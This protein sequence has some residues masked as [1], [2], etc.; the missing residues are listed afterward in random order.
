MFTARSIA[1]WLEVACLAALPSATAAQSFN[2]DLNVSG[3][4]GAGEPTAGFVTPG[5]EGTWNAITGTSTLF[6]GL[7][8][9]TNTLTTARFVR[10]AGT[11]IGATGSG[12]SADFQRLFYDFVPITAINEFVFQGLQPGRYTVYSY[13]RNVT[14]PTSRVSV[15]V[16][17]GL[18]GI[19]EMLPGSPTTFALGVNTAVHAID[20]LANG[21][22]TIQVKNTSGI[23]GVNGFQI[24]R[25][26][27]TRLYVDRSGPVEGDGLS[28]GT[29]F[30]EL[31]TAISSANNLTSVTEIW[32]ADGT[33]TPAPT[34]G[35]RS[36]SFQ[37][38]RG[39]AIYGGFAGGE[40]SLSQRNPDLNK[41]ILSG[42]LRAD[43]L[44]S[45]SRADNSYRVLDLPTAASNA[46]I[47][48]LTISGGQ[49]DGPAAA[50]Q[51]GAGIGVEGSSGVRIDRCTIS[52]NSASGESAAAGILLSSTTGTIVSR[53]VFTANVS[54]NDQFGVSALLSTQGSDSVVSCRFERNRG[55]LCVAAI[56]S[57]LLQLHNSLIA[58]NAG[59][60]AP[61]LGNGE[62]IA[63]YY[64]F[65]SGNI[66]HCTIAGNLGGGV[67]PAAS[68]LRIAN[69]VIRG[70]LLQGGSP[71]QDVAPDPFEFTVPTIV[72]SSIGNVTGAT[73]SNANPML[74]SILGNDLAPGSGD[75]DFALLPAS[76]AADQA[77]V[78]EIPPDLADV[79]SDGNTAEPLPLDLEGSPRR[80]DLTGAPDLSGQTSSPDQGAFECKTDVSRWKDPAGATGAWSTAS[81]WIPDGEPGADRAAFFPFVG[82]SFATTTVSGSR[83]TDQLIVSNWHYFFDATGS[84]KTIAVSPQRGPGAV[85]A[86]GIESLQQVF[87]APWF[88]QGLLNAAGYDVR[89]GDRAVGAYAYANF[90]RTSG[91]ALN[92]RD[93]LVDHG[94]AEIS[95]GTFNIS[96]NLTIGSDAYLIGGGTVNGTVI[97]HGLI[98]PSNTVPP[99]LT[100]NGS[101]IQRQSPFATDPAPLTRF[102]V[103]TSGGGDR[104]V[105]N[106]L[107]DFSGTVQMS[108]PGGAPV[109]PVGTQ[110][111]ILQYTARRGFFSLASL[112]ATADRLVRLVYAD[113]AERGGGLTAQVETRTNV[114]NLQPPLGFAV[115]GSPAAAAT[116]RIHFTVDDYPDLA[117]V[118]PDASNPTT[119]N[120]K[121]H[122]LIN[123]GLTANQWNGW[124]VATIIKS[125]DDP[126]P[127]AHNGFNPSGVC[128]AD[129]TGDGKQDVAVCNR[130]SGTV[131]RF[132]NTSTSIANSLAD[133]VN[134]LPASAGCTLPSSIAAGDL[135]GDGDQDLVVSCTGNNQLWPLFNTGGGTFTVPSDAQKIPVGI[136]P[137]ALF[138]KDINS[139]GAPDI[140]VA[141][142]GSANASII[143]N[144]G[145][146]NREGSGQRA[147]G[148]LA[149]PMFFAAG[150]EPS[151][152]QPG[153]VDN[154]KE[155]DE[156]VLTNKSSGT[157]TVLIPTAGSFSSNSAPIGGSPDSVALVD[158]DQD[159]RLDIVAVATP[160][161]GTDDVIRVLQTEVD[162]AGTL[163]LTPGAD[164]VPDAPPTL[165]LT[166]DVDDNGIKD[167]VTLNPDS[168]LLRPASGDAPALRGTSQ[169][170]KTRLNLRPC[171]SDISGDRTTNTT[172]LTL[173]LV[174]FGKPAP[175]GAPAAVADINKDAVVN[176]T[177]LTLLLVRFGQPCPR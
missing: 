67:T 37:I 54:T 55:S 9:T 49:A 30:R 36:T 74:I 125:T 103:N 126:A 59:N 39:Y 93:L 149:P 152:I 12:G 23:G 130:T 66:R 85:F 98:G 75:E 57:T 124:A 115:P 32:V 61:T 106:G 40:T 73:I 68:T 65:T 14:S 108:L 88:R 72:N 139:D 76:P 7:R 92:C 114:V 38:L 101:L 99:V 27:P 29:A 127:G 18:S 159:G 83:S 117:V 120:G 157:V 70:N 136:A 13:A 176:T 64:F 35:P 119:A 63:V 95:G 167:L 8:T 131:Q 133:G 112:P 144:I 100:I 58:G 164:I 15:S 154:G 5:E 145:A 166:A 16:P 155:E 50:F 161:G 151:S 3:G 129:F 105:I 31:R 102:D 86:G 84:P 121:L 48:G 51:T 77:D 81:E 53:C 97:Q 141:N 110:W 90:Y 62:M 43:D 137:T 60:P 134:I 94:G 138:I 153:N 10:T 1:L 4:A 150:D 140:G 6:N 28:W 142:S 132:N 169:S 22:I 160:P 122:I 109:P 69:S 71:A 171:P 52:G 47:D 165:V 143:L 89:I 21:S 113:T 24:V 147:W 156:I 87:A 111:P 116:G 11:I 46:R 175:P 174:H 172:D 26:Q 2:I 158:A 91:D 42:D 135:D 78:D 104:L 19:Q 96:R 173:L 128:I 170:I 82:T 79:D 177:D 33:Y 56:G 123:P 80:T 44:T 146:L 45:G 41:A 168:V 118:V 20:V 17:G 25:S 34:N 107:A 148:G 162:P 163:A